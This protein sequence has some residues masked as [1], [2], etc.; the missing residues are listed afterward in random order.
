MRLP[1]AIAALVLVA[2]CAAKEEAPPPPPPPPPSYHDFAGH[3]MMTSSLVGLGDSISSELISNA[4]GTE[5][6]LK[7]SGRDL[8]PIRSI[9]MRADSLIL[10]SDKYRSILRDRA[11]V[12]IRVAAVLAD[13]GLAG[14][15]VATYDF[16]SAP[17]ELVTGTTKG[18]K[19]PE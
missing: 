6:N 9:G 11:M 15:L 13:G 1:F 2:G 10:V 17:Q 18:V 5:W 14:K 8:V 12:Q 19:A 3:W 4:A 16:P 7:L